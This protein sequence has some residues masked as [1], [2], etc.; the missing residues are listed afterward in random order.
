MISTTGISNEDCA[1]ILNDEESHFLDFKSV[2]IAPANLT[3]TLSALSNADGGEI[4][5]GIE[6]NKI[7]EG[8]PN[9]EAANAHIATIE[10]FFPIEMDTFAYFLKNNSEDGLVLKIEV[11]KNSNIKNASDGKTYVR[12]G[13]Q[14]IP[15]DNAG[16][17]LLKRNKGI[18][19]HEVD[20]VKTDKNIITDSP[21]IKYF[22]KQV[23][24][25]TDPDSW[26][27]KQRLIINNLPTVAGIILFGEE[28]QIVIPKSAIKIYQYGTK[29]EG[30]RETLI[31]DPLTIEGNAYNI[32]KDAV[33]RVKKIIEPIKIM[34]SEGFKQI[35]YPTEAL[36]EIITNAVLHR[37]Y[38]ISDD[39]HIRIYDNRIEIQSPG[40][41]PGHITPQNILDE[42]FSRNG[43]LVRLINKFPNPPNKD[44][45]EGLNTAFQAMNKM[46]LKPPKIEVRG[47]N[48]IVTLKHE[49]LGTPEH[50]IME[51][52][53]RNS[54]IT[55]K[56]A[57]EICSI[58]SENSMKH[59]LAKMTEAEMITRIEGQTVFQTA[60][61]RK[62]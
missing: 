23:V 51:Y 18:T 43:V 36:H 10:R 25:H 50:L 7:W 39:I 29:K 34:T 49:S 53:D 20:T 59:I 2:R 22:I 60:Y 12:R 61:E 54:R 33:D 8:F 6:D 4:Y 40:V 27:N 55:N 14:N 30:D 17:E 5:I 28:P 46:K 15:L 41:L 35:H 37:D 1:K 45:G 24:P 62:K 11:L 9:I 48:V 26:L 16:L 57:R 19:S 13:A 3:K 52:L 32:I 44:V 38:S 31:F 42:R 56:Q 47:M 58:D 21:H